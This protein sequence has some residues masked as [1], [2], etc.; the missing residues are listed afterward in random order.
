MDSLKTLHHTIAMQQLF[1][2]FAFNRVHI[3]LLK[4]Y[5]DMLATLLFTM[6]RRLCSIM[7]LMSSQSH[8]NPAERNAISFD[9]LLVRTIV[10]AVLVTRAFFRYDDNVT[11]VAQCQQ[12]VVDLI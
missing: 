2:L 11:L 1:I 6:K 4:F 7:R 12:Y 8:L 9:P 3:Q 5:P 10:V